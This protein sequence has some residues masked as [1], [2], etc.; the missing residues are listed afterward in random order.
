MPR[1][2]LYSAFGTHLRFSGDRGSGFGD[3]G[4]LTPFGFQSSFALRER[5]S[6]SLLAFQSA[7]GLAPND[8]GFH[9]GPPSRFALRRDSRP[10]A[11][12]FGRSGLKDPFGFHSG[13]SD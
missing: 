6:G 10:S 4:V 3:L 8:F 5:A 9:S 2:F 12:N 13:F 11:A 1:D 7:F